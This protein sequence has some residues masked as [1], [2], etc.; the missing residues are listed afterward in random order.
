M[1]FELTFS[2]PNDPFW[3]RWMVRG[4][5]NLSGRRRFLPVYR[6]WS[7]IAAQSPSRMM[8][9]LLRII[10]TDV[11]LKGQGWPPPVPDGVPLVLIAN[12]PFG[13][14]D[15]IAIIALAEQLGRPWR[16]LINQDLL[17]VPEIRPY[18]LPIDFSP[19]RSAIETGVKRTGC[20][21]KV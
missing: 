21:A 19:T 20:C 6:R 12:H 11:N 16:I 10:G 15:G 5:E 1:S 13:I 4:I 14:G 8:T 17:R 3:R 18:A 9:E 7:E 2:S